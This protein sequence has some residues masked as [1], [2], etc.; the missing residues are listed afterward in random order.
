MKK[1]LKTYSLSN[2][3]L[4]LLMREHYIEIMARLEKIQERDGYDLLR[5]QM[6]KNLSKYVQNEIE[7]SQNPDT[8]ENAKLLVSESFLNHFCFNKELLKLFS[9]SVILILQEMVGLV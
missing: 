8:C 2:S 1:V 5:Y 6:T 7:K 9:R 3:H 4:S